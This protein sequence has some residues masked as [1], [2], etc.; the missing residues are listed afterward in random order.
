MSYY[1][2]ITI[3]PVELPNYQQQYEFTSFGEDHTGQ[4]V[5]SCGEVDFVWAPNPYGT[6]N[7]VAVLDGDGFN[8]FRHGNAAC[9]IEAAS[10]CD[11]R[12]YR[13]LRKFLAA[14]GLGLDWCL[15]EGGEIV[16]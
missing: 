11:R 4:W 14:K 5:T 10:C 13:R 15:M 6:H 12:T 16:H 7:L 1:A 8:A 2:Q 9:L 3:T